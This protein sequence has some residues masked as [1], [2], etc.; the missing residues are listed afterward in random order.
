MTTEHPDDQHVLGYALLSTF[1][2]CVALGLDERAV[3]I[4][5][6]VHDALP[7][8]ATLAA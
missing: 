5:D 1:R 6:Y 4:M 2:D 7:L 8:D 3:A